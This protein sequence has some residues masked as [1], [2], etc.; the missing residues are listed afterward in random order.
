[1]CKKPEIPKPLQ[2][3]VARGPSINSGQQKTWI[4]VD[5]PSVDANIVRQHAALSR[6]AHKSHDTAATPAVNSSI[7]LIGL[8]CDGSGFAG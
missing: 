4:A 8:V 7:D 3:L 2:G 5:N 6:G 1:M